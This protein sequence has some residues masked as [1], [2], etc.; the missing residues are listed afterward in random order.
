VCDFVD[1]VKHQRLGSVAGRDR[2]V[3][4]MDASVTVTVKSNT[5][6]AHT[7]HR[8]LCTDVAD[9]FGLNV[10]WMVYATAC[11]DGLALGEAGLV[12]VPPQDAIVRPKRI[13]ATIVPTVLTFA[14][15]LRIVRPAANA[16]P[17][18]QARPALFVFDS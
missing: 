5:H 18:L 9:P 8:P 3:Y 14:F 4:R 13:V 6:A 10:I 11:V 15:L 7:R 2:D 12:G 16:Y 1:G 17:T